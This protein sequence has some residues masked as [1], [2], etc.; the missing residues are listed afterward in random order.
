M[1]KISRRNLLILFV[2]SLLLISVLAVGGLYYFV[3]DSEKSSTKIDS[4]L[5]DSLNKEAWERLP[6]P[7]V[8]L[9][10]SK[11]IVPN[12]SQV[13]TQVDRVLRD[14]NW[15]DSPFNQEVPVDTRPESPDQIVPYMEGARVKELMKYAQIEVVPLGNTKTVKIDEDYYAADAEGDYKFKIDPSKLDYPSVIKEDNSVILPDTH[16]FN[17]IAG[18]TAGLQPKPYL[19]I[20]C[21]DLP[22][23]ADAALYLAEGGINCYAPCDRFGSQILGYNDNYEVKGTIIGTA[24]VKKHK[25]EAV[26]GDQPLAFS[27]S[28]SICVQYTDKGYP[29]QYCDTPWRYFEALNKKYKLDLDLVKVNANAGEAGKVVKKAEKNKINTIAVRVSEE[30]DADSVR[31]WLKENEYHKAILFHSA[32]YEPGY[33]LFFEFPERVTFGDLDPQVIL[34]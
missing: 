9:G 20:A 19:A 14:I 22:S 12:K 1:E 32:P 8:I 30:E 26:I 13:V 29:D 27:T 17:S 2:V 31:K 28:E 24:P 18:L 10:R 23:K 33:K 5:E 34:K 7:K 11:I 15:E 4:E 16:G 25:K 3:G 6:A 21:M